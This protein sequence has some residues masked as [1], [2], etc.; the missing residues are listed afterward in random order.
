M[1]YA[2]FA[3]A[4]LINSTMALSIQRLSH[5]KHYPDVTF[6]QEEPA[7]AKEGEKKE[8]VISE[9]GN[10]GFNSGKD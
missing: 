3:V 9:F 7:P 6:L 5:M 4:L 2:S 1:K 8:E 10:E